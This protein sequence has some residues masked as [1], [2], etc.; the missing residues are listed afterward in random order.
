MDIFNPLFEDYKS[1]KI[2]DTDLALNEQNQIYGAHYWYPLLTDVTPESYLF[3][4]SD[5]DVKE[6]SE[7]N[8]PKTFYF[9][10][11]KH[12]VRFLILNN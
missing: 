11:K 3:E 2:K 12:S 6:L 10:I 1:G 7:G 9:Q 5:N 4:L 8:I